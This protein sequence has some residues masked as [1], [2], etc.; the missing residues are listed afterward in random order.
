MAANLVLPDGVRPSNLHL[1]EGTSATYIDQDVFG[2]CEQI[3]EI[4]SNLSVIVL[5]NGGGYAFAIMERGRDGVE[6]LILRVKQLDGRVIRELREMAAVPLAV[7][8]K[9]FE[10]R[11]FKLESERHDNELEELYERMGGPMWTELERCGFIQRPVSYAKRGVTGAKGS[12]QK[13]ARIAG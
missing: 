7:R 12:K 5:Q 10:E 13:A 11:E 2:I 9:H 4:D 3:R 1:P 6:H 8:L